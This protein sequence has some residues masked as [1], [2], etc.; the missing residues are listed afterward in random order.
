MLDP[1]PGVVG[2]AVIV[3]NADTAIGKLDRIGFA[4]QDH[5][6]PLKPLNRMGIC[7]SNIFFQ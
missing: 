5:S 1:F 4:N 6:G 7:G 3:I 2:G